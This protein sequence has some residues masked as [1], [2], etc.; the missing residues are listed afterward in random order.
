MNLKLI[1]SIILFKLKKSETFK[2]TIDKLTAAH[3]SGFEPDFVIKN[4]II[5]KIQKKYNLDE[6]IINQLKKRLFSNLIE[7]E[8]ILIGKRNS[9]QISVK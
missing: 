7:D 9:E 1:D 3:I 4:K 6:E 8:E 5:N 2:D